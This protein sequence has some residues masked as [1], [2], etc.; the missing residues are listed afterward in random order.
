MKLTLPNRR[1]LALIT[2]VILLIGAFGY[3]ALRSGPLAPI[4]VTVTRVEKQVISPSLFGIGSVDA[5]YSYLIGPTV[6]GRIKHVYVQVGDHVKVGQLLA[7]MD[8]V[9]LD[10][11]V[12]A[13]EAAIKRASAAVQAAE[14]QVQDTLARKNYAQTEAH[15]YEQLLQAHSTSLET[16]EA[17]LQDQKVTEASNAAANANLLAARQDVIRIHA[18]RDGLIQQHNNLQLTA[19][20]SGLVVA[21]NAEPGTTVV[22]GQAVIQVI[23]P[24]SV[25]LNV[26]FDQVRAAGLRAG[27]PATVTLRSQPQQPI[28]GKILRV[29]P[30]ADAVT[31]EVLAKVVFKQPPTNLPPLGEMAEVTVKLPARPSTPVVPNAA[32]KH[33]NAKTGVWLINAEKLS[34]APVQV[35]AAD[36]DGH[37]QILQGLKAGDRVVVYSQRELSEHSRIK[38]VDQLTGNAP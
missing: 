13:Q 20:V 38:I 4:P 6:A 34:F 24:A 23:D 28:A 16:L 22:A 11:R 7:E 29:E 8:P 31:E 14:A 12:A 32:L 3:V 10:N 5:Q 33:I 21:R 15:R 18:D 37:V 25:W 26:R 35:G 30:L 19:T 36:L 17:K 9:D 1:K 27:L 2:V